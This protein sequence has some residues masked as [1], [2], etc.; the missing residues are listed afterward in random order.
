[1]DSHPPT[2]PDDRVDQ[3]FQRLADDDLFASNKEQRRIRRR[4]R[5]PDVVRIYDD[6]SIVKSGQFDHE[7]FSGRAS[8]PLV[9]RCTRNRFSLSIEQRSRQP[10][11]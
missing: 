8:A 5:P 11:R 6:D 1:M 10:L 4:I 9:H 3:L 7:T 2:K